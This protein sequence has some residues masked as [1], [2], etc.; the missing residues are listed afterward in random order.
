ME[1]RA[2]LVISIHTSAVDD[3]FNSHSESDSD[4]VEQYGGE[5]YL[6]LIEEA[7]CSHNLVTK[8]IS[9]QQ[10]RETRYLYV[11]EVNIQTKLVQDNSDF[12]SSLDQRLKSAWGGVESVYLEDRFLPAYKN[13]DAIPENTGKVLLCRM[14][15][16][17][18]EKWASMART[19][20]KSVRYCASCE[21]EVH[22]VK[23]ARGLKEAIDKDWCIYYEQKATEF[24]T[25]GM[26]SGQSE[27]IAKILGL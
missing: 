20:D 24:K 3:Y 27:K 1:Y 26:P 6:G 12:W 15:L 23:T 25:L 5:G 2:S 21:T 18:K 17:C 22:H 14:K 10:I 9:M 16:K 8:I 4:S 11:Y 7:I 13:D 19:D